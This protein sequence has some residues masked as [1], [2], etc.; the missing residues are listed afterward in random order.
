MMAG[1]VA[2]QTGDAPYDFSTFPEVKLDFEN[3]IYTVGGS[4]VAL[5]TLLGGPHFET[6]ALGPQGM[7]VGYLDTPLNAP[8][9]IGPLLTA[10]RDGAV[11]GMTVVVEFKTKYG[12]SASDVWGP[13]F[14][15]PFTTASNFQYSLSMKMSGSQGASVADGGDAYA[16][17][18]P[19][20]NGGTV[21]I[22]RVQRAVATFAFDPEKDG[23]YGYSVS[24]NGQ[25]PVTD[26]IDYIHLPA[27]VKRAY[28]FAIFDESYYPDEWMILKFEVR[29]PIAIAALA[30]LSALQPIAAASN[31]GKST[32]GQIVYTLT[33]FA[34]GTAAANRLCVV[35]I[36]ARH[37]SGSY[38]IDSV[39][40][41]GIAAVRVAMLNG[42]ELW[43]A[44]VPT[45]TTGT[46][47]VSLPL[48]AL[49]IACRLWHFQTDYPAVYDLLSATVADGS[50]VALNDLYVDTGGFVVAAALAAAS[51]SGSA[52]TWSGSESLT[53]T[54]DFNLGGLDA[55]GSLSF[56]PTAQSQVNDV[57]FNAPASA[58]TA[59]DVIVASWQNSASAPNRSFAMVKLLCGFDGVNNATAMVDESSVAR[60]LTAVGNAKLDTGFSVYGSASL[61]LDGVG[62][63]VTSPASSD[64]DF[65]TSYTIEA[66]VRFAAVSDGC[67][68]SRWSATAND[69]RWALFYT[70][71][72]LIW[73]VRNINSSNVDVAVAWT[74]VANT[75]YKIAVDKDASNVVRLYING[76]M[77]AST[78]DYYGTRITGT[79]PLLM[80]GAVAGF[81]GSFDF[82]GWVEELRI[83]KGLAR[84]AS[85]AGYAPATAAFPR[86]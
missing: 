46:V 74:P 38:S 66:I 77:V 55:I 84:Y 86:T 32:A 41:A 29:Q 14:Y 65:D 75:I 45:G 82:N 39:T 42:L 3:A 34:L 22:G 23:S 60:A 30:A 58:T 64:F 40:I 12:V 67:I 76:V 48:A 31:L 57:V 71:G 27:L 4:A 83:T 53:V 21:A 7:S 51:G 73:R 37:I 36:A 24:A 16:L 8:M 81:M 80:I 9:A 68:V 61:R 35:A 52:W 33:G 18:S 72:L 6:G 20:F 49:Q 13:V 78:T 43:Q 44:V 54:D 10:M 85:N 26:F 2:T 62:D 11:A 59:V 5:N 69:A 47:V 56:T 63:Y 17:A 15:A 19:N 28:L 1:A 70:A 50:N 79:A 25:N